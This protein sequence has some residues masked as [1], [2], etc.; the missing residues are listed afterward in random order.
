MGV[1]I[2]GL[3]ETA[4]HNM[5]RNTIEPIK[6]EYEVVRSTPGEIERRTTNAFDILFRAMLNCSK[7][8]EQSKRHPDL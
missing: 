4:K 5:Q 7:T 8:P 2:L 6:V 1:F 3:A